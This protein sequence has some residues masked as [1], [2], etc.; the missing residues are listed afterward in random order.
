M[1]RIILRNLNKSYNNFKILDN[2]SCEFEKN[3]FNIIVG[4]SG[5]GKTT[6]L[7]ILMDLERLDSGIIEGMDK[8][9]SPVFQENR[10]LERFSVYE[11]ISYVLDD[12]DLLEI[13]G[14]LEKVGLEGKGNKIVESLSGGMKRRVEIL[15]GVLK[16]SDIYIFDEPFKE[17]DEDTYRQTIEFVRDKLE[18]KTVIFTTHRMDEI[19]FFDGKLIRI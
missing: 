3:R 8:T 1:S 7:N 2:F 4:S 17:M 16:E 19:Q 9:V 6:L 11:N 18:G 5:I 10:L 12:F 15:K 14:Y 13:D